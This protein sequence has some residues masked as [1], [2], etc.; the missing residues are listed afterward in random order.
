MI[1]EQLDELKALVPELREEADG[2]ETY[3]LLPNL[4]LP[5][6]CTPFKVDA[7]LCTTG[8]WG[9]TCRLF[10]GE[11]ISTPRTNPNWTANGVQICG[12]SWWAYS[13]NTNNPNLRYIQMVKNILRG[14]G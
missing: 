4:H 1:P 5:E 10:F 3:L 8:R 11:K 12:Q 14:L 13:W 2:G 7:L 6:W 9:Y